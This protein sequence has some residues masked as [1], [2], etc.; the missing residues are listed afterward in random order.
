MRANYRELPRVFAF[1]T[2]MPPP[3]MRIYIVE[4]SE[5]DWSGHDGRVQEV[6]TNVI[7]PSQNQ[8]TIYPEHR[9]HP[10][11]SQTNMRLNTADRTTRST[12]TMD[13]WFTGFHLQNHHH[14]RDLHDIPLLDFESRLI[15]DLLFEQSRPISIMNIRASENIYTTILHHRLDILRMFPRTP[16]DYNYTTPQVNRRLSFSLRE[17]EPPRTPARN[18][19]R[20]EDDDVPFHHPMISP[21]EEI[22]FPP[23]RFTSPVREQVVQRIGRVPT[24]TIVQPPTPPT[25]FSL[26]KFVA[27]AM[28]QSHIQGEKACSITMTPFKDIRDITITSC[29][30]CFE[31]EALTRWMIDNQT[32]PECRNHVDGTT[33]YRNEV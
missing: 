28:V 6:Y 7:I 19:R 32:C 30:H 14:H 16:E 13:W 27:Q 15:Q 23:H 1:M 17:L 8:F 24:N 10:E 5:P 25:Q 26:P 21:R 2:S 11:K 20:R 3:A 12:Y 18:R 29:Y 9:F 22:D 4:T 31:Q 33:T